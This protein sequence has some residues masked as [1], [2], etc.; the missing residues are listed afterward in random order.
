VADG[1]CKTPAGFSA[2][3]N[4]G[5]WA[6]LGAKGLIFATPQLMGKKAN[7]GSSLGESPKK[8]TFSRMASSSGSPRT[9]FIKRRVMSSLL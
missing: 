5:R 3:T 1:P 6:I 2:A 9:S 4:A 8:I 7:M